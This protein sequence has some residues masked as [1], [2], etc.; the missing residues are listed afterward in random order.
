MMTSRLLRPA[1]M[2]LLF[3]L[4]LAMA[5]SSA[6]AQ[7]FPNHI[8]TLIVPFPPG[9]ATDMVARTVA[10]QLSIKWNQS[11]LVENRA[12]ATGG[13]G[14]NY[15]ARSAPDGYT[16]LVATSSSHT[17][18]PNMIKKQLWDPIKDFSPVTLLTWAP[19]VLTVNPSVP[20]KTIPE[21]IALLKKN[22]GKY[23]FASS[24]TGS[25]IQ[26]AGELFKKLAG[27]DMV[28][29][30]YK[31]A[32]P[33]LADLLGGQVNMMFDTVAESLP[34]IK[35]GK[36]RAL[37]VTTPRR[38][39]VLADIPTMQEAGVPGYEMSA[40]IGLMAPANT[41]PDV[42]DKIGRDTRAVLAM[43]EV[44]SRFAEAGMEAAPMSS[45]EFAARIK[46]ELPTYGKLMRDAGIQP[47]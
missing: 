34:L 27:V 46:M 2:A 26:L 33:A 7:G 44:E 29:V 35:S 20:A 43:P 30:P 3:G 41:P 10:Q 8:V 23:T 9:A 11:V 6:M 21:L 42:V 38:S 16:L 4:G 1:A 13:I 15:V 5:D 18:G 32:A 25:S 17:M 22:P 37:A 40:W 19:N 28:H 47:E 12:G 39:S 24:G 31:G 45:D 14:S 36:L